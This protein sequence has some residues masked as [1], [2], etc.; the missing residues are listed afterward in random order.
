MLDCDDVITILELINSSQEARSALLFNTIFNFK[1]T[2]QQLRNEWPVAID[3]SATEVQCPENSLTLNDGHLRK[4]Q[5]QFKSF[6]PQNVPFVMLQTHK[7]H[8]NTAI[9]GACIK[10]PFIILYML[11]FILMLKANKQMRNSHVIERSVGNAYVTL[12]EEERQRN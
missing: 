9:T 6:L 10:Q 8:I 11:E 1:R 12:T 3:R 2:V 5:E 7:Y 4:C